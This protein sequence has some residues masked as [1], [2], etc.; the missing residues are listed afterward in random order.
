MFLL[1]SMIVFFS[2]W[3]C[4]C[5]PVLESIRHKQYE[6]YCL[7]ERVYKLRVVRA[8]IPEL[9]YCSLDEVEE[10]YGLDQAYARV[11]QIRLRG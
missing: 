9:K 3:N 2:T 11:G 1:V 4:I 5:K 7:H 8:F 10:R 6:R